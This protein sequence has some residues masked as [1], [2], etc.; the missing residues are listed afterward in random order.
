VLIAHLSSVPLTELRQLASLEATDDAQHMSERIKGAQGLLTAVKGAQPAD[1]GRVVRQIRDDI[2]RLAKGL[3]PHG[4][5]R[6]T[7]NELIGAAAR[8]EVCARELVSAPI[9]DALEG[10]PALE[11]ELK[12][13]ASSA[14]ALAYAIK[15]LPMESVELKRILGQLDRTDRH[16][17][18]RLE[19]AM[20]LRGRSPRR[21]TA[22]LVGPVPATWEPSKEHSYLSGVAD[23]AREYRKARGEDHP[24][25]F[26][27]GEL[28]DELG[29]LRGQVAARLNETVLKDVENP[30]EDQGKSASRF[31][32]LTAD[33]G[34]R[35]F[36]VPDE[37]KQPE[38]A[39]DARLRARVLCTTCNLD[40]DRVSEERF[41]PASLIQ[42]VCVKGENEGIFYN[43]QEH[44]PS[45]QDDPTF[46]EQLERFDIFG[47]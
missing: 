39:E 13:L 37:G 33:I 28:S 20:W 44:D 45:N 18:G 26:I 29:T 2:R 6:M 3:A 32:A 15:S 8:L 7:S 12:Q 24:G 25:L 47:R 35:M 42:E 16:L 4:R 22:D 41:H 27:I 1:V 5:T 19:F 43:C 46:L 31:Y 30:V 40:T 36:V 34:L 9:I 11:A 38:P 21:V 17:Q 14:R 10:G 23:W